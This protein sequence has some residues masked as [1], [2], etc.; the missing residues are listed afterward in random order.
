MQE[1]SCSVIVL[2]E[3]GA[4]PAPLTKETALVHTEK[5]KIDRRARPCF[6]PSRPAYGVAEPEFPVRARLLRPDSCD[7]LFTGPI[8]FRSP[9]IL[10]FNNV[11]RKS[12]DVTKRKPAVRRAF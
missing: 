10:V 1:P 6:P 9:A 12:Y 2:P 7:R 4:A 8:R 3:F 11:R 5:I